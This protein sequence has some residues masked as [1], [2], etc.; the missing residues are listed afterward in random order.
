[1]NTRAITLTTIALLLG[2]IFNLN[3]E[4]TI[5]PSAI[6]KHPSRAAFI[7]VA[8]A[9]GM[10]YTASQIAAKYETIHSDVKEIS[11]NSASQENYLFAHGI[12]ETHEQAFW[13]TKGKS[14]LP[15]LIN[16]R[17]FTYDYPD[18]IKRFWRVNFTKTGLG[19]HNEIMGLKSAYDQTISTLDTSDSKN[20]DLI[21]VGMSRGATSILN[22]MGLYK[23]NRIKAIVAES[24]FDSTHTI[25][26]NILHKYYLDTIP[27]MQTIAHKAISTVF[28]RHNTNG[29]QAINLVTSIDKKLPILLICSEQ[30]A[31]VP[32][33][34]TIALY[35][36]LKATGHT[37]VHLFVAENGRHGRILH[38]ADGSKYQQAVHAFYKKYGLSHDAKLADL[39]TSLL[40]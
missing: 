23:P 11:T 35:E 24:P 39:G 7:A 14:S 40:Q 17:L 18:A 22:F 38:S 8:A 5:I 19:Q 10:S 21:L 2:A 6:K 29:A 26:K 25:A 16:G 33:E 30:D 31:L 36:K 12:A 34:S 32:A 15:Y 1:M 9:Y 37:K 28:W 27:G 20:K 3:T 13:Y 4:C